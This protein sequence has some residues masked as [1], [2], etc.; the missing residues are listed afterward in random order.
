MVNIDVRI[1]AATNKPL[2]ELVKRKEFREDLFY[3]LHILNVNIPPLRQR[4]EDIPELAKSFLADAC[5]HLNTIKSFAPKT[6]LILSS[7]TWPGNVRELRGA[8][9]YLA[10]MTEGNIIRPCDLHPY[11]FPEKQTENANTSVINVNDKPLEEAIF[12]LEYSMIKETL[13][14]EGSTY[15]AAKKLG[16]SQSTVVRKAKINF[17]RKNMIVSVPKEIKNQEY[18]VGITPAGVRALVDAGHKVLVEKDAGTAIGIADADYTAQGATIVNT[19]K[20]AW[21]GDMVVKVKEPLEP[22]YQYFREGMVLFTYLHLVRSCR[23]YGCSSW[24][25]PSYKERRRHGLAHGR[26]RWCSC[27]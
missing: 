25:K 20:E 9:E 13:I 11:V 21:S 17:R 24:C 5:K 23:P 16:I 14:Q 3:R 7:Y 8:V 10:A 18:R 6:L 27:C 1:I 15:K 12:E 19:A 2:E 22:E 4:Q 26:H